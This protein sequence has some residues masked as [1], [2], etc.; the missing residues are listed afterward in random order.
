M[1]VK[2]IMRVFIL[3]TSLVMAYMTVDCAFKNDLAGTAFFGTL[4]IINTINLVK[5][6]GL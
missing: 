4:G 3:T 1:T 5:V 6:M 2:S